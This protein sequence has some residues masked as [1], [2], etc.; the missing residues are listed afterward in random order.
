MVR[1]LSN[2][3][4]QAVLT[5]PEVVAELELLYAD[6]GRGSAVYRG[7]TDLFTPTI[8]KTESDVPSA[9][10]FKTLDGAIP[11]LGA[12]SIRITSD[13]VAFPK[14]DGRLRRVKLPAAEDGR[15]VGLVF[16]FSS[17]T[18]EPI[19]VLQDGYLQGLAVGAVNAIGAK[20]LARKDA[21]S[22]G[23][24][25]AGNQARAQLLGLKAVRPI[26]HVT[27]YD[28]SQGAAQRLCDEMREALGVPLTT[29]TSA[30]EA[31]RG[32]DIAVT[33]TNSR[34][35]FFPAAWLA[36][37]MHL[38]CMQRD[39]AQDDCFTSA[40]VVVFHTPAREHE[41]VSTDFAEMERRHGFTMRDHPPRELD[42]TAFPDLG[43]LV[44]G[45]IAGRTG[46]A[47]RTFFLN[48][49]G[50]G[51]VYTAVGHLVY[52]KCVAQGLGHE[53]PTGWFTETI[54]P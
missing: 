50:V 2:E 41:F 42:W 54:V 53:I 27:V 1:M 7:R 15:Y 48:S 31:V 51:A 16:L 11:R 24:I 3:D 12:A 18:G 35:P 14:I 38:S 9:H 21:R 28:A 25:G 40:D 6:L 29:A 43:A 13:V 33:A 17:A 20:H 34:I 44:A 30:K 26:S 22:V 5:M 4:A 23:L 39:E 52:R 8:A 32:V 45:T 36:P 47:A 49:T 10:Q 46:D 37:G 19:A